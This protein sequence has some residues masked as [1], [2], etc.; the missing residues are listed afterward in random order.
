MTVTNY[1]YDA[2]NN[3][4]TKAVTG[5]DEPGQWTYA[6]NTLNQL[7]GFT[8]TSGSTGPSSVSY[9]YDAN[10]NR[11]SRTADGISDTYTWDAENRLIGVNKAGAQ[12]GYEYDYRTRR[13]SREEPASV[14]GGT[15]KTA[16]IFAGG[17][18]VAEYG[19]TGATLEAQPT[20][21]YVRG[22]DL[23]GGVGGLLYSLRSAGGNVF[24]PV[25]KYNYPNGRGDVVAQADQG[26]AVTWTASY[27]AFG[28]HK[29]ETGTNADRQRA[30]TK[31]ED[32]TG[33]LNEGFRYRDIETGTWLSRDPAGFVDGPNL[34]GYVRCNPWTKFDPLGLASNWDSIWGD[35]G[36]M[37]SETAS[38]LMGAAM[39]GVDHTANAAG[40][41]ASAFSNNPFISGNREPLQVFGTLENRTPEEQAKI[42]AIGEGVQAIQEMVAAGPKGQSGVAV[43]KPSVSSAKSKREQYMGST[44][45]KGSATGKAVIGRMTEEGKIK[46]D[47]TGSTVVKNSN[48]QWVPI[49]STD[50]SHIKDAVKAWNEGLKDTGAKSPEVRQFMRDPNNYELDSSSINRSKGGSMNERYSDPAPKEDPKPKTTSKPKT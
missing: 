6:S 29:M 12:H 48:D 37:A 20:V 8:R 2:A 26:G 5:G 30:N 16:V 36:Q 44:P 27:E 18:S 9:G 14:G 40:V 22:P 43:P 19:Y 34:Y 24:Q 28:S 32:P 7:T 39:R 50:M 1:T 46:N 11:T 49:S 33:L 13:I 25:P 17:L 42:V 31:E 3:R 21:E 23:G 38:G 35:A 4:S 45:G 15:E 10:G 47:D 41:I